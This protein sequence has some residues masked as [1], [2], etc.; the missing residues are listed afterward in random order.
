MSTPIL[1]C[2]PAGGVFMVI[3]FWRQFRHPLR[4]S[5]VMSGLALIAAAV[6]LDFIEGLGRAHSWNLHVSLEHAWSLDTHTVRHFSK[7]IE[8]FLEML[9]T[10]LI[11]VAVLGHFMTRFPTLRLDFRS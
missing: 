7:S 9:G 1:R 11:W 8:E 10:T 4:F 2:E 5:L 6:G 3:F